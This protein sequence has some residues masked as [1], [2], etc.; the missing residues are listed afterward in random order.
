MPLCNTQA[1]GEVHGSVTVLQIAKTH[2]IFLH[3]FLHRNTLS[4]YWPPTLPVE[5]SQYVNCMI[6]YLPAWSSVS[7]GNKAF[8]AAGKMHD[9]CAVCSMHHWV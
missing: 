7:K 5:S 2:S 6:Y 3:L 1:N 4:G 8:F 9:R